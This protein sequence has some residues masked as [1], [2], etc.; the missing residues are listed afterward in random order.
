MSLPKKIWEKFGLEFQV[1]LYI[2][3]I[4]TSPLAENKDKFVHLRRLFLPSRPVGY[5]LKKDDNKFI[6][7]SFCNAEEW[8]KTCN[9][10]RVLFVFLF[11]TP[12]LRNLSKIKECYKIGDLSG[13][14]GVAGLALKFP[15]TT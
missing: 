6:Y 14:P 15:G 13:K 2:L 11:I 7:S 4:F 10:L 1:C 5:S 8:G 3:Y 9:Y 12:I